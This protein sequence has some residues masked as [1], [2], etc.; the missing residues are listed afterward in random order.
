VLNPKY[1]HISEFKNNFARVKI[2]RRKW[3]FLDLQMRE[4]PAGDFFEVKDFSEGLAA[5]K[6]IK[7]W[8]F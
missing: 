4:F 3:K 7:G 8:G 6:G 1:E 5:V 2:A